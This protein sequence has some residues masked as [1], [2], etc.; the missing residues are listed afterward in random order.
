MP[1]L[2]VHERKNGY[3]QKAIVDLRVQAWALTH[4]Q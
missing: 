3:V 4:A 2:C 1:V